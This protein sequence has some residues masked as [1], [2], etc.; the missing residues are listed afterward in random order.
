MLINFYRF[1][2]FIWPLEPILASLVESVKEVLVLV[3]HLN[4][5][6]GEVYDF[7]SCW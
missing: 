7:Q 2:G 5:Q 6:K 3:R 4:I 1:R